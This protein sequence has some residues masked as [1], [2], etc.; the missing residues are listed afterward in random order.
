M[1]IHPQMS[2]DALVKRAYDN[3]HQVIE[4][5]GKVLNSLAATKNGNEP[6]N[7]PIMDDDNNNY[8]NEANP[9]TTSNQN[10]QQQQQQHI[11]PEQGSPYQPVNNPQ[12]ATQLIEYPF[13]RPD[14]NVITLNDPQLAFSGDKDYFSIGTPMMGASWS[15]NGHE[16]E[17]F[18]A[19]DIRIRSSEML[20]G[21]DMQRLLRTFGMG[22]IDDGGY[23]YSI[24]GY[25]QPGVHT[26]MHGH[27]GGRGSGG[28]GKA[29]VGW[30]KLKAALR[31]GIFV[32]K[33]AAEKR[34]QLVE[35]D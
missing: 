29:V 26:Y 13:M 23:S 30:L 16:M 9:H 15:R 25:D 3:W 7:S 6:S 5:D 22:T 11:S 1:I 19:E 21:D 17:D 27:R 20:E 32:R 12:P 31:W 8:H 18:F 4:Y 33:R 10:M 24:P 35:L 2:V 14:Q 34:A 28:S